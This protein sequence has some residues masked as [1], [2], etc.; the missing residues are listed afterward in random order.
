[1][2][3]G[4]E[5]FA[6]ELL[7]STFLNDDTTQLT[8]AGCDKSLL[9]EVLVSYSMNKVRAR[10]AEVMNKDYNWWGIA[11][12]YRGRSSTYISWLFEIVVNCGQIINYDIERSI[13]RYISVD[14]GITNSVRNTSRTWYFNKMLNKLELNKP[15]ILDANPVYLNDEHIGFD[16]LEQRF[17]MMYKQIMTYYTDNKSYGRK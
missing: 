2:N 11:V 14:F 3:T 10:Y 15:V 12:Y 5:S 4:N 6:A 7:S 1:M 13:S 9:I 17:R 16:K 8:L